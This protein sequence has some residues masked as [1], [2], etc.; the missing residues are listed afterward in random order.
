MQN[1]MRKMRV[2]LTAFQVPVFFFSKENPP[3]CHVPKLKNDKFAAMSPF[4][5]NCGTSIRVLK[6]MLKMHD[7]NAF[8]S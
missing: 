3:E 2:L 7:M 4:F 8:S 6:R 1:A 5:I